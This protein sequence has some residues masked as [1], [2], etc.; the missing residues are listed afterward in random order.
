[1]SAQVINTTK[2]TVLA[3]QV[4]I[5]DRYLSR[6]TG[7][8]GKK[9]L[10]SDH[11]LWIVPCA[12]IHSFFMRFQFDAVFVDK[13]LNVLYTKERMAPWRVSRF[14]QKGYAVLELPAGTVAESQTQIGDQLELI[15][16]L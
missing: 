8:M 1:M 13:H 5:A 4:T 16:T 11:G 14:V 15:T 12:D 9:E 6:L 3:R 10:E 2:G 7:L